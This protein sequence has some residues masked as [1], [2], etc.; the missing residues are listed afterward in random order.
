MA[1]GGADRTS[2]NRRPSM[3]SKCLGVRV[4][5]AAPPVSAWVWPTEG[6]HA[7]LSKTRPGRNSLGPRSSRLR[8]ALWSLL[9]CSAACLRSAARAWRAPGHLFD[10]QGER[11]PAA[12]LPPP[13]SRCRLDAPRE[14]SLA[15]VAGPDR[16]RFPKEAHQRAHQAI[17][18]LRP[19]T[20]PRRPK[21]RRVVELRRRGAVAQPD[22]AADS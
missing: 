6:R 4:L 1:R 10:F 8:R 2:G 20:A 15:V 14:S 18:R 22:R 12:A 17:P 5:A 16:T 11:T 21:S 3:M 9:R 19:R 13:R 7:P